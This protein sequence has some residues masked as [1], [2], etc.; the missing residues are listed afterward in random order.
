MRTLTS[1]V[2]IQDLYRVVVFLFEHASH[3]RC[4]K[5]IARAVYFDLL[6]FT[7]HMLRCFYFTLQ[8]TCTCIGL[9]QSNHIVIILL[10]Q[11]NKLSVVM[12]LSVAII[13]KNGDIFYPEELP[14]VI[15][16]NISKHAN[17]FLYAL[18]IQNDTLELPYIETTKLRYIF[19]ET[20]DLYWLIVTRLESDMFSDIQLL[21]KFVCTIMEYGSQETNSDSL[22]DEQREL[23]YRHIWRPW[24]DEIQC[25]GCSIHNKTS[26][27]FEREFEG[28]LQFLMDMRNG[29]ISD[30]DVTYFNGLVKECWS[31]HIRLSQDE[32]DDSDSDD[33]SSCGTKEYVSEEAVIDGVGLRIR[34]DDIRIV[35]DRMQDPYMRLYANR[36]L[37]IGSI[38][39]DH[40]QSTSAPPYKEC[41]SKCESDFNSSMQQ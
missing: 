1:T 5:F 17:D 20:G 7:S 19:K 28:R 34:L 22:T 36:D 26:S 35:M 18:K 2:R 21:G 29:N 38:V 13:S 25:P 24:D 40:D 15:R 32:Y 11:D 10:Q 41:D 33:F 3:K 12:I 27:C 8:D 30:K 6:L 4:L 9:I 39:N 37:L 23:F 16:N 14:I 31:V